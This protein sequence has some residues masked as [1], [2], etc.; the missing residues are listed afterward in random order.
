MKDKDFDLIEDEEEFENAEDL[1][2]S[3]KIRRKRVRGSRARKAEEQPVKQ[4]AKQ[5]GRHKRDS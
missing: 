4:R 5:N 1:E 3:D 2:T